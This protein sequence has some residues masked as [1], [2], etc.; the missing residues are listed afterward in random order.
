MY[1]DTD[2]HPIL[3]EILLGEARDVYVQFSHPGEAATLPTTVSFVKEGVTQSSASIEASRV[4]GTSSVASL[5][6]G[7]VH[8]VTPA[9]LKRGKVLEPGPTVD[10]RG[11]VVA[12]AGGETKGVKP[13]SQLWFVVD[14]IVDGEGYSFDGH[15]YDVKRDGSAFIRYRLSGSQ[16]PLTHASTRVLVTHPD[17]DVHRTFYGAQGDVVTNALHQ[18]VQLVVPG[19]YKVEWDGR[20]TTPAQRILLEGVYDVSVA[21]TFN[22]LDSGDVVWSNTRPIAMSKPHASNYGPLYPRSASG[23]YDFRGVV[24]PSVTAQ[25]ALRDG[26]GYTQLLTME[27]QVS[28]AG[29]ALGRLV[30]RDAVFHF[31]GQSIGVTLPVALVFYSDPAPDWDWLPEFASGLAANSATFPPHSLLGAGVEYVANLPEPE[32][33]ERKPLADAF[34]AVIPVCYVDGI[35]D[36]EPDYLP[37]SLIQKGVDIVV[38]PKGCPIHGSL[39][40]TWEEVFWDCVSNLEVT[41]DGHPAG[42]LEC[43]RWAGEQADDLNPDPAYPP[44]SQSHRECIL[45]LRVRTGSGVDSNERLH[46]ARYGRAAN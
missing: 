10:G 1:L 37:E 11:D 43:S 23:E 3:D 28:S 30:S 20:D 16:T 7:L 25:Q 38:A 33:G 36:V 34:L 19:V 26:T 22:E 5:Y 24:L 13:G 18:S 40:R 14:D 32:P 42:V 29:Q 8:L 15:E 6:E 46:P 17:D 21:V 27:R 41:G 4:G 2:R 31:V 39:G 9:G 35:S 45:G 44:I 12:E